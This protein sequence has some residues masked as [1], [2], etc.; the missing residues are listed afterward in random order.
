[1]GY[2]SCTGKFPGKINE[3]KYYIYCIILYF[4]DYYMT[5][6]SCRDVTA[7]DVN[8][9]PVISGRDR[10]HTVLTFFYIVYVYNYVMPQKVNYTF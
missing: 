2:Q 9:I 6:W 10:L 1:M 7:D 3:S 5:G 8:L 4:R